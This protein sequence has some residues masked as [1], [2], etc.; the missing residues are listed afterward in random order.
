MKPVEI[1]LKSQVPVTDACNY[2]YAGGRDQEDHGLKPDWA[3]SSRDPNLKKKI[4]K[5]G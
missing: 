4:T 1:V 2:K 5:K 3:S